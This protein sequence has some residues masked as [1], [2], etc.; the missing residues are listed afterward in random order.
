M[1][2]SLTIR[3]CA[4]A[5]GVTPDTLRYYEKIGLLTRVPRQRNG[6]RRFGEEELRWIIFL[7]KL[8]AT[9]MPIRRMQQYAR[10]LRRGDSTVAE[11]RALLEAHREEVR[12]RLRELSQNL[13]MIEK[14]IAIYAAAARGPELPVSEARK[15]AARAVNAR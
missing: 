2:R 9:G 1:Q 13:E 4:A 11:R 5:T 15:V 3:E 12:A 10:L 8:H 14:K 6:H 7:R